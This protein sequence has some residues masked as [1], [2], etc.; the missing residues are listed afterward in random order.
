MTMVNKDLDKFLEETYKL[1]RM[2]RYNNTPRVIDES[3]AEHSY[4]VALIVYRLYEDYDF[5]LHIAL[6]MALFHDLPE[7]FL[8]DVPNNTK[9][10]FP[11]LKE[12]MESYEFD[13]INMLDPSMTGF[14]RD[15]A[16]QKTLESMIV[17]AADMLSII[18]YTSQEAELGNAYMG[19]IRDDVKPLVKK[20]FK[21]LERFKDE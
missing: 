5:D 19:R 6:Q 15:Y 7:I 12:I 3:V 21:A 18:Q 8:S 20:I 11:K 13:A 1:K 2:I 10:M 16:E 4:F 14:I 9:A 17:R